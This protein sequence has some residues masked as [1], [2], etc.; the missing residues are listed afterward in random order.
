M[1]YFHSQVP[2]KT[3]NTLHLDGR[4]NLSKKSSTSSS[5]VPTPG[6]HTWAVEI[7]PVEGRTR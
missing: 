3:T 6:W 7:S 1:E 4:H 5:G 2:G